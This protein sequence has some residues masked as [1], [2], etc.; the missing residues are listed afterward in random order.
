MSVFIPPLVERSAVAFLAAQV[1]AQ[2]DEDLVGLDATRIIKGFER[3][4]TIEEE[5]KMPLPCAICSCLSAGVEGDQFSGNWIAELT[6]ELR[7]KV[8]DTS[9]S[10]H[11]LMAE[12]LFALFFDSAI[13]ANLSAAL[14]GFSALLVVPVQQTRAIENNCWISRG[15]FNV[16]CCGS[17]IA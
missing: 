6:V 3:A 4:A 10:A 16:R 11:Q 12:E 14:A 9:S 17:D 2:S 7:T 5:V 1:F 8:F 13:A 15:R